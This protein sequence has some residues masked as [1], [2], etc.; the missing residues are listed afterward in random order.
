MLTDARLGTIE[1]CL[2]KIRPVNSS[3]TRHCLQDFST[4]QLP[5]LSP[6]SQ[7]TRPSHH[8]TPRVWARLTARQFPEPS[9]GKAESQSPFSRNDKKPT[10]AKSLPKKSMGADGE[11]VE[12]L[13]EFM[14]LCSRPTSVSE[15]RLRRKSP[16]LSVS[17]QDLKNCLEVTKTASGDSHAVSKALKHIKKQ[18][19][20][21][22]RSVADRATLRAFN[23]Q[24]REVSNY[25][26]TKFRR[27]P[28][29]KHTG[30][31]VPRR[32]EETMNQYWADLK[33]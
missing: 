27:Q 23:N 21:D 4:F 18:K 1:K 16:K 9:D 8:L 11:N 19:R 12:K 28:V 29:W 30:V 22:L 2:R 5:K 10:P 20:E 6:K 24:R 31:I 14:S 33:S 3:R 26:I 15:Q 17:F 25:I 7:S 32:L 13:N